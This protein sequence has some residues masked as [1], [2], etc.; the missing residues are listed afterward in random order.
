MEADILASNVLHEIYFRALTSTG[1]ALL[2]E[3]LIRDSR[4]RGIRAY[5][6]RFDQWKEPYLCGHNELP[7]VNV[8][9]LLAD[10]FN[11]VVHIL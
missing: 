4:D 9:D 2:R 8:L 10:I 3:L 6:Q 5:N 7:G 1:G 11:L